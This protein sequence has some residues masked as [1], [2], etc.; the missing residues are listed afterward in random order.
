MR[1]IVNPVGAF[2]EA[3]TEA[4]GREL[5]FSRRDMPN[6]KNRGGIPVCAPIFGPGDTVDLNQHGFARNVTWVID[7]Q[8]ESQVKLSLDNPASQVEGLPP[9][10]AGLGM[11]LTVELLEDCLRETLTLRNIGVE[12][13]TVSPAFHP[14]FPIAPNDSAEQARV[15]IDSQQYQLTAGELAATRK[16]DS[17]GSI[18]TLTTA[19]GIWT[20][21][22][23]GLPFFA[24]WSESPTNF[25]CV[26]PT[27]S[28]YLT[29]L[30]ASD[31]AP[32]ELK[33]VSITVQ[34]QPTG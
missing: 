12:P 24:L 6:G 16:I 19:Q 4:D 33:T 21:S 29:D 30:P 26:E 3:W 9:V 27:E 2:V 23:E 25:I 18:A 34:F 28:G 13:C 1:A 14:Y 7:G 15:T 31:L 5:L 32:N 10:Y 11:E 17:I 22:G 8:T 20:I